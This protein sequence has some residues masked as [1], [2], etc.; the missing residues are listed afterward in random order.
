MLSL[1]P[2][3]MPNPS[4]MPNPLLLSNPLLATALLPTALL[5]NSLIGM[6]FL[7]LALIVHL[8]HLPT[9]IRIVSLKGLIL[10]GYIRQLKS[11]TK[12]GLKGGIDGVVIAIFKKGIEGG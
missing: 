11:K 8:M 12:L 10:V 4:L 3:L 9:I 1:I 5:P 7:I 2:N 6:A